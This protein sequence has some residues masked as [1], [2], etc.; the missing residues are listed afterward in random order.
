MA[1]VLVIESEPETRKALEAALTTAGHQIVIVADGAEVED[2]L[3]RRAFDV[4]LIS[5]GAST[6]E[7]SK[8][9]TE[10]EKHGI[11]AVIMA[12]SA[13]RVDALRAKGLISFHMPADAQAL[14]AAVRARI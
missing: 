4:L 10:T 14:A 9:A 1:K 3:Q 11:K 7:A 12:R 6:R 5:D 13:E 2:Q 8:L